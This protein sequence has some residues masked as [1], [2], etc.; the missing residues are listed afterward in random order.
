MLIEQDLLFTYGEYADQEYAAQ[1]V[2]GEQDWRMQN[3]DN[4]VHDLTD[5]KNTFGQSRF[6]VK[7]FVGPKKSVFLTEFFEDFV[8]GVFFVAG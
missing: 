8:Q 5:D 7:I 1:V 3:G 6:R 4:G 2:R